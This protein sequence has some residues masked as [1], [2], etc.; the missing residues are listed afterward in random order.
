MAHCNYPVNRTSAQME[1]YIYQQATSR[2]SD[3]LLHICRQFLSSSFCYY[4]NLS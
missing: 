3:G 1:G 2:V 4:N